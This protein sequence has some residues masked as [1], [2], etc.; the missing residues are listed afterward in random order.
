MP[1]KFFISHFDS[2]VLLDWID[3]TRDSLLALNNFTPQD[4]LSALATELLEQIAINKLTSL[5]IQLAGK[6]QKDDQDDMI[7]S[8][9]EFT[10]KVS[11]QYVKDSL[12]SMNAINSYI[13]NEPFASGIRKDTEDT[14]DRLTNRV[15]LAVKYGDLNTD[16][17]NQFGNTGNSDR[18]LAQNTSVFPE[19]GEPYDSNLAFITN[20]LNNLYEFDV[21]TT[22]GTP[23]PKENEVIFKSWARIS[24]Q[25]KNVPDDALTFTSNKTASSTLS[26]V[27]RKYQNDYPGSY[28]FFIEK[29]HGRYSNGIAYKKNPISSTREQ[30]QIPVELTNRMVFCAYINNFN[31]NYTV[32]YSKYNFLG[33]GEPLASYKQTT[34]GFTLEFT[35]LADYSAQLIAAMSETYRQLNAVPNDEL[36]KQFDF[37]IKSFPADWGLGQYSMPQVINGSRSGP[38]IAG[39]YSDTP[40]SLWYKINFLAQCCY[41]Y[42]R[43][44]GKMKEQPF[45][46][47]RVGVFYDVIATITNLSLDL[48]VFDDGVMMDL[49]P[50]SLGNIPL[51]I[52]ITMNCEIYH[53]AEPNSTFL[54]FYYRKEFDTDP[55]KYN[56]VT[57]KGLKDP[58]L[59]SIISNLKKNSP[60]TISSNLTKEGLQDSP[61]FLEQNYSVLVNSLS[62]FK[63]NFLTLVNAGI[64]ISDQSL[65]AKTQ[66]ALLA[67]SQI[68]QV[69]G[70]FKAFRFGD[71]ASSTT[72]LNVGNNLNASN[73]A[74]GVQDFGSAVSNT[75]KGNY[76]ADQ[77]AASSIVNDS[78]VNIKNNFNDLLNNAKA[79]ANNTANI[80]NNEN[81]EKPSL[82]SNLNPVDNAAD[83]VKNLRTTGQY[84]PKTLGDIIGKINQNN[85]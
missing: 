67:Y 25:G 38:H 27:F 1:D 45:V 21:K 10:E 43:S 37:I 20:R 41:P 50:S 39:M 65:K 52:R 13:Q 30:K 46:R 66:D 36:D 79:Q 71:N 35:I 55:D 78:T 48:N 17:N 53:D 68:Q 4:S 58:K 23:T 84:T 6:Q 62:Q 28:K 12:D 34:R 40:E 26:N 85:T 61:R 63:T 22:S 70:I 74:V 7:A 29:L 2:S 9:Q 31:D 80:V 44:D 82:Q 42:Y 32:D 83:T 19:I 49:N 59:D 8:E 14:T 18:S 47:I 60:A 77:N 24:T 54:G 5:G 15:D 11:A 64:N 73:P 51:G 72:N 16:G 81:K 57:G 76:A 56:P 75:I 3:S 33:R 69:A